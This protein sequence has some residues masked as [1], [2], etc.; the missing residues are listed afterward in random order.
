ML[1]RFGAMLAAAVVLAASVGGAAAQPACRNTGSFERWLGDFKREALSQGITQRT[2]AAAGPSLRYEAKIVGIDR[3]GQKIFTQTF[4]DFSN[5]MV[6]GARVPR[7]LALMKQHA[8]L[9]RQIE[10]QY[11]VPPA[12]ITAYWGLESDYGAVIGKIETLP[13][14]ATLAYD[15]RRPDLFRRELLA[16]LRIVQRG[17][18]APDGMIG[19]WAGEL[20]Q[21][22][23]LPSHY[24][25]HGVDFDRDGRVDLLRSVPDVLATTANYIAKIGWRRGEPWLREVG[26]PERMDWSQADLEIRHPHAQWTAWGVTLPDGTPLPANAPP[27][28][29]LLPMGRLGP[30]FLAYPNFAIYTEWNHSLIYSTTAA[31]LATRLAGAPVLKRGNGK[32]EKFSAD[33][34][35]ELQTLLERA[36]YNVGGVDGR[37]GA[38]TRKAIQA[39]QKKFGLDADG[40][41]TAELFS[42]LRRG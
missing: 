37:M 28:S 6:G 5:R 2:L 8:V 21:T 4:I 34:V 15:C 10:Q 35:K 38:L 13:S 16:A 1:Q 17:D 29:L 14:L 36:G 33:Q 39:A 27:A 7:G 3:S 24:F 32:P 12:V 31:Y 30:A 25:N 19:S 40:Y 20:G 22:Q 42:R 9:F 41:P 18:L 26:V 23:F 11:G